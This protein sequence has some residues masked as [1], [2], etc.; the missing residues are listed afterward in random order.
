M[1]IIDTLK[2]QILLHPKQQGHILHEYNAW[3]IDGMIGVG[4][5]TTG[6]IITRFDEPDEA[7]ALRKL[8]RYLELEA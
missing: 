7:T 3:N 2:G 5:M 6:I 8:L 1:D 4:N